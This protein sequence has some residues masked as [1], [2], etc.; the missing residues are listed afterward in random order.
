MSLQIRSDNQALRLEP[1]V[2]DLTIPE[3]VTLARDLIDAVTQC[4][5]EVKMNVEIPR[6]VPTEMQINAAVTRVGHL[7]RTAAERAWHDDRTNR[8]IVARVLE[9]CL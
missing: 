1:P 4:G 6:H 3:A 8:E 7:R 5:H 9:A 2:A